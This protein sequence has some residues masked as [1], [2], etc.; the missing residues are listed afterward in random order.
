MT[1]LSACSWINPEFSIKGLKVQL[2]GNLAQ[3]NI[4]HIANKLNAFFESDSGS[5]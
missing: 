3:L 2:T 4:G 5:E 1:N